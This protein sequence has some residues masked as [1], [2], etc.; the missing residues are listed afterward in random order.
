MNERWIDAA[1][2][3][4]VFRMAQRLGFDTDERKRCIYVCPACHAEKRH[5]K[6]HDKRGAL[7]VKND[8]H[9]HCW[10]CDAGGD[11]AD[12]LAYHTVDRRL[13]ECS[14]EELQ[15][16][17][18]AWNESSGGPSS[19]SNGQQQ[20]RTNGHR[21]NGSSA[22]HS[23]PREQQQQLATPTAV[24][25]EQLRALTDTI[26]EHEEPAAWFRDTRQIDPAKL[27][28]AID[29]RYLRAAPDRQSVP[30]AGF[31]RDDGSFVS[32]FQRGF[33]ILFPLYDAQGRLRSVIARRTRG[34]EGPKSVPPTQRSRTGFVLADIN[35]QRLLA[36]EL[37]VERGVR[38]DVVIAEGEADVCCWAIAPAED[39]AQ[40]AVLG[41]TSGAWTSEIAA[42]IPAGARVVIAT[43]LDEPGDKYATQILRTLASR[44]D[45]DV[46]RWPVGGRTDRPNDANDWTR[47]GLAL[48][49][50]GEPMRLESLDDGT[51]EKPQT[52][53]NV[54][55]G[56]LLELDA[57]DL[58]V[59]KTVATMGGVS[60]APIIAG[61]ATLLHGPPSTSK[62]LLAFH[63]ACH[64]ALA[65]NRALIIEG[66]GS[67]R[68]LRD[69]LRRLSRGIA[70]GGLAAAAANL[71]IVHGAFGLDTEELWWRELLTTVKPALVVIDPLV[72]YQR[73]D[74]N[75]AGDVSAFLRHVDVAR[76]GECSI[77]LLH[78]ARHA[79]ESGRTRER[80]SSALRAW[81][82]SV[83][84]L[85]RGE[86]SGE[87]VLTHEKARDRELST[88]QT[89]RWTFSEEEIVLK[90]AAAAK[91]AAVTAVEKKKTAILL[92]FLA[93]QPEGA[94][95]AEVRKAIHASGIALERLLAPLLRSGH[96]RLVDG[97]RP[98]TLGR[99]RRVEVLMLGEPLPLSQ[100]GDAFLDQNDGVHGAPR[101]LDGVH[102]STD[103]P[104]D[105][106]P[107]GQS[108]VTASESVRGLVDSPTESTRSTRP[109]DAH[110]PPLK[111]GEG[112]PRAESTGQSRGLSA[113]S[114]V[115]LDDDGESGLYDH[116]DDEYFDDPEEP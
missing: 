92:G 59:P 43:D 112:S 62:T 17:R 113:A 55:V 53:K 27:I 10:Q 22:S 5:T 63:A 67:R 61:E 102:G 32:W 3:A 70:A 9:W 33:R 30:W 44:T 42:R 20:L 65:G 81:A 115:D 25:L 77:I 71:F 58:P 56:T 31:E 29:L 4:G 76:Q 72:A 107:D 47:A 93:Q 97:N 16:V 66:E 21:A 46:R 78:H 39:G 116:D 108:A 41:V 88:P 48:V 24:E 35:G 73:G 60:G 82:D 23:R 74:E 26:L 98:D 2:H 64:V 84:G 40:R 106:W 91:D 87:V 19:S 51:T 18:A 103:G 83:V 94:S 69:R 12:L 57:L 99:P 49:A 38:L 85:S 28:G 37:H 15:R 79:D 45:L 13:G 68:G 50:D 14:R 114:T 1:N 11:A 105:N 110:P 96:V 75:S 104:R 95:K 36:G 54:W 111:G 101:G 7:S 6:A 109:V 86:V 8:E 90:T 52:P 89:L 100:D 34:T 80:G